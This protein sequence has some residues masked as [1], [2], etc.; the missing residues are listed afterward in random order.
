MTTVRRRHIEVVQDADRR[1]VRVATD[2]V[3]SVAVAGNCSV[4]SQRCHDNGRKQ[5]HM[6]VVSVDVEK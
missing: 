6:T 5:E 2:N 3:T 4:T 1:T